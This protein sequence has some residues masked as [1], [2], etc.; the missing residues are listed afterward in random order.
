MDE[1]IKHLNNIYAMDQAT[2]GTLCVLCAVAAFALKDYLA[3]PIMAIF[4]YPV[5]VVCSVLVQYIFI[6][7][8]LYVPRRIDQ[9]LMWTIMAAI[10][11]NIAGIALVAVLGR[12]RDATTRLAQRPAPRSLR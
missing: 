1:V 11:G 6:L 8:E 12:V 4:A 5:L 7:G 3:F 2:L 10:C 9:W